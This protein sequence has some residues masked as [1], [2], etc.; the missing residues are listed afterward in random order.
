MPSN[1]NANLKDILQVFLEG[2]DKVYVSNSGA[3]IENVLHVNFKN[4]GTNALF[5]DAFGPPP[6]SYDPTVQVSFVYGSDDSSG[7]LAPDDDK[8]DPSVGSAWNIDCAVISS[9]GNDWNAA[10]P[11]PEEDQPTWELAPTSNNIDVIG[12]G[13]HDNITFRFGDI[14]SFTPAG[15]TQMTF[16]FSGFMQDANTAYDEAT[17]TLNIQKENPPLLRG[18]LDFYSETPKIVFN[19][20]EIVVHFKWAM[21]YVDKVI[22][23]PLL[24]VADPIEIDYPRAVTRDDT[25]MTIS[26]F[27]P[28]STVMPFSLQAFDA[29]G[30]LLNAMQFSVFLQANLFTDAAGKVYPTIIV[31]S[32]QW[33][34]ANLD[35][36]TPGGSSCYYRQDA[37]NEIPNGRL[38]TYNDACKDIPDGWRLPTLDEWDDL[39]N[40]FGGYNNQDTLDALIYGGTSKFNVTLSGVYDSHSGGWP[41]PFAYYWTSTPSNVDGSRVYSYSSIWFAKDKIQH[42]DNE[43]DDKV[44]VRYVRDV[45]T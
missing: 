25:T 43:V 20:F 17:F 30:I 31:G 16:L 11:D 15:N 5:N 8:N 24:P 32:L 33:M 6:A 9:Q 39:I 12:T 21:N 45:P 36:E 41:G 14:V 37:A 4:L 26:Y 1:S 18:I 13:A 34:S 19:N 2:Q 22:L 28:E 27:I 38:Y 23:S 42:A 7:I 40:A 10:G 3:P 44:S 29:N 35:Y